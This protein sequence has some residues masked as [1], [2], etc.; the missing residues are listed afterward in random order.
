MANKNTLKETRGSFEAK[1]VVVGVKS[2][3]FYSEKPTKTQKPRRS[4]N[5]RLQVDVDQSVFV[6]VAGM[7][8][9]KV[10]F[11]PTGT[12]KEREGK[13][14]EVVPW[15]QRLKFK[16]SGYR[17]GYG[18]NIGLSKTQDE[19]GDTVNKKV[20]LPQYDAC[21]Y[22]SENL[23]D[24][25]HVF[26]RGDIEYSHY[27]KDGETHQSV[28][29][30]A[31][32]ISLCQKMDFTKEDFKSVCHFKQDIIFMGVEHE[33]GVARLDAQIARYNSVESNFFL[34]EKSDNASPLY[35]KLKKNL[36]PY[37]GITISGDIR[38]EVSSDEVEAES[39]DAWGEPSPM[40]RQFTSYNMELFVTGA[41]P[42]SIDTESY[43]EEEVQKAIALMNESEK[44][45]S[46]FG[47]SSDA[48]DF[49][50]DEDGDDEDW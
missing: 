50:T 34:F 28:R 48:D 37:T 13:E 19:N 31:T 39:E 18:V 47:E 21:K 35:K 16:K 42:D 30:I 41:S 17:L 14:A 27:T 49:D 25:M 4:I 8:Q 3:N 12:K 36:K 1:G 32:Q 24:D 20:N 22:I 7:E 5:F 45:S 10:W 11:Y 43:P 26:I 23:E 40:D 9:E 15:N 6:S 46:D 38:N 2:N 29:L 33:D 44:A